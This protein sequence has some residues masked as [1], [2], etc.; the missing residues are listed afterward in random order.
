MTESKRDLNEDTETTDITDFAA[1]NICNTQ[2]FMLKE[3]HHLAVIVSA[4]GKLSA[5]NSISWMFP[6]I[7]VLIR[8]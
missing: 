2:H 3:G 6:S 4:L 5:H 8:Y 7:E 1:S